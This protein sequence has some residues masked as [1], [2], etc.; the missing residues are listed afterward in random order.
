MNIIV[1]L[2]PTAGNALYVLPLPP[3]IAPAVIAVT[4]II[5]IIPPIT[6]TP[7]IAAIY[8]PVVAALSAAASAIA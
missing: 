1:P 5:A 8:L 2:S 4:P 3:G 7:P 6:V